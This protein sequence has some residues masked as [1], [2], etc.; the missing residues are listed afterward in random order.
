MSWSLG[1]SG[2]DVEVRNVE[3]EMEVEVERGVISWK[4]VFFQID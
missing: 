1:V 2:K 3:V 4:S